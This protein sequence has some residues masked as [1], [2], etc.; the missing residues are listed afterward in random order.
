MGRRAAGK[1]DDHRQ[2]HS[3][4]AGPW[5]EFWQ[6]TVRPEFLRS[7]SDFEARGVPPRA[8][9]QSLRI[10]SDHFIPVVENL[11]FL[12]MDVH[13]DEI[14]ITRRALTL[15][16]RQASASR[17]SPPDGIFGNDR[18]SLMFSERIF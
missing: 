15:A 4:E 11:Y 18:S 12:G 2:R 16:P 14:S 5:H 10:F 6:L 8:L 1:E 3:H 9:Q 7:H 13:S 17:E